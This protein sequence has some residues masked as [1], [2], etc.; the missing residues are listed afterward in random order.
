M[1]KSTDTFRR[2]APTLGNNILPQAPDMKNNKKYKTISVSN[3]NNNNNTMTIDGNN[4]N[5]NHITLA[6][7]TPLRKNKRSASDAGLDSISLTMSIEQ[8]KQIN[9]NT[10]DDMNVNN[11]IND[12]NNNNNNTITMSTP[13]SLSRPS[14]QHKNNTGL[15]TPSR[16]PSTGAT[17]RSNDELYKSTKK[18]SLISV[19]GIKN[20]NWNKVIQQKEQ[21]KAIREKAAELRAIVQEK[22]KLEKQKLLENK[23]RRAENELKSQ[24]VVPITNTK[25]LKKMNRKQLRHIQ[26][27]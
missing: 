15:A 24:V 4:D 11:V 19:K 12:N 23:K 6:T 17:W 1:G 18:S 5:N 13:V 26:K 10:D 25:K 8:Y 20:S 7:T 2:S 22:R 16:I 14:K 3:N 9:N 21:T 27:R